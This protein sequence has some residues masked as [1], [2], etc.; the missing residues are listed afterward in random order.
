MFQNYKNKKT[1]CILLTQLPN[2]LETQISKWKC[3]PQLTSATRVGS[4]YILRWDETFFDVS[5]RRDGYAPLYEKRP[6]ECV[7]KQENG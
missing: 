2:W 6:F 7:C 4:A 1:I 5:Y 3:A